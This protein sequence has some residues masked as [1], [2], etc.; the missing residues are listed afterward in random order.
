MD[1][2]PLSTILP[3]HEGF[4]RETHRVAE[5]Q[6]AFERINRNL[7]RMRPSQIDHELEQQGVSE[8]SSFALSLS[9]VVQL[10]WRP[11]ELLR[12]RSCRQVDVERVDE[13][14]DSEASE[15]S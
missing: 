8:L 3:Q 7:L 9:K 13:L 11:S 10:P 1:Q 5:L 2:V 6:A 12:D 4:A 15:H 14:S